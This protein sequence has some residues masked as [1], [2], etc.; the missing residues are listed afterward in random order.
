MRNYEIILFFSFIFTSFFEILLLFFLCVSYCFEI[1]C[2]VENSVL[3]T[4]NNKLEY[5]FKIDFILQID[6]I[7]II[8]FKFISYYDIKIIHN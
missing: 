8:R 5:I 4:T 6:F 1:S 2:V 3:I 7:K